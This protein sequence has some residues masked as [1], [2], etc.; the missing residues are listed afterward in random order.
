MLL[1]KI[2]I[3]S[4]ASTLRNVP[5]LNIKHKH[6]YSLDLLYIYKLLY[7][8]FERKTYRVFIEINDKHFCK[9]I[10]HDITLKSSNNNFT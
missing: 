3:K 2:A 8:I 1:N 9:T 10:I 5:L 4:S 7:Q 6:H